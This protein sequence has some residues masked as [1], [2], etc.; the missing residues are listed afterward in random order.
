MNREKLFKIQ[1]DVD[2]EE[3]RKVSREVK[4]I[5]KEFQKNIDDMKAMKKE[6]AKRQDIAWNL[7]VNHAKD[8]VAI[9][10]LSEIGINE[11]EDLEKATA[12]QLNKILSMITDNR[13]KQLIEDVFKL[14]PNFDDGSVNKNM[15]VLAEDHAT[16]EESV[17]IETL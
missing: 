2:S 17:K 9:H 10:K 13:Y 7:I 16:A 15:F 1:Y 11:Q 3:L 5:K 8:S 4:K 14:F 6:E 12:Q